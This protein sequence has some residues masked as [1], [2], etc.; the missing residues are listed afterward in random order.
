MRFWSTA[1]RDAGGVLGGGEG[2]K[3]VSSR[4]R[5]QGRGG[6]TGSSRSSGK[7][8]GPAKPQRRLVWGGFGQRRK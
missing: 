5:G 3:E 2:V 7:I 4:E 6:E 8:V 1:R